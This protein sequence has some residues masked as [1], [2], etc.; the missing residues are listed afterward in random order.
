MDPAWTKG[1]RFKRG[2]CVDFV[3]QLVPS[4]DR[5]VPSKNCR[6]V[7]TLGMQEAR[8]FWLSMEPQTR[9]LYLRPR[10]VSRGAERPVHGV[11]MSTQTPD[12]LSVSEAAV[13]LGMCSKTVRRMIARGEIPARRFGKRTLRIPADALAAAGRPVSVSRPVPTWAAA[14]RKS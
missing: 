5:L 8:L 6:G 11:S 9:R 14:S 3:S 13:R 12:Y 1:T 2:P 7:E 10:A 4:C